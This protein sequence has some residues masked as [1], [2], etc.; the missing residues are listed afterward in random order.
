MA[1]ARIVDLTKTA[2]ETASEAESDA[3]S[4]TATTAAIAQKAEEHKKVNSEQFN[5]LIVEARQKMND[6][7]E[8]L[9]KKDSKLRKL[10]QSTTATAMSSHAAADKETEPKQS[11]LSSKT[12][13]TEAASKFGEVKIG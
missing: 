1:K 3:T 12:D 2:Y 10:Q 13:N 8:F 11:E 6:T 5:Y 9:F 4:T 7:L